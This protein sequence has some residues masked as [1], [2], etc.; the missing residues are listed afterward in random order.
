MDTLSANDNN[1]PFP[2]L[3]KD[4]LNHLGSSFVTL[5]HHSKSKYKGDTWEDTP[6]DDSLESL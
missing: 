3:Q 5:A 6:L 1:N 4:Q 2:V